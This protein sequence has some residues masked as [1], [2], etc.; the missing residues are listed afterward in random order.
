MLRYSIT[1]SPG[2]STARST[3]FYFFHGNDPSQ[4]LQIAPHRRQ[5]WRHLYRGSAT[6]IPF[7]H[8]I[9]ACG[10]HHHDIY[11]LTRTC[12]FISRLGLLHRTNGLRGAFR[13]LRARDS[14]PTISWSRKVVEKTDFHMLGRRES[15][16]HA[17]RWTR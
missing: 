5:R 2:P 8:T 15:T 4:R 9:H 13:K 10:I 3:W 6:L 17:T 16:D 1:V 11:D 12:I 14:L 7:F